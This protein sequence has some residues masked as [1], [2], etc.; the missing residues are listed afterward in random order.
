MSD[1]NTLKKTKEKISTIIKSLIEMIENP[2]LPVNNSAYFYR[3]LEKNNFVIYLYVFKLLINDNSYLEMK[4]RSYINRFEKE[5][6]CNL[7]LITNIEAKNELD[8]LYKIKK[9]L[10]SLE[11]FYDDKINRLYFK[12]DTY[13]DVKWLIT[14]I[15]LLLDNTKKN[16]NKEINICYTIPSKDITKVTSKE[17]KEEFLSQFTYYNI[18]VKKTDKTRQVRENNILIVKNAAINYLKHLK[19][20]KHGLEDEE[21]YLIFYNLLKNECRKEGFDLEETEKNL[22]EVD[23]KY[24]ERI[25]SIIDDDFY[26]N[27]L[28]KQIHIIENMVWQSSND[29]TLL[30]HTNTSIDSFIDL[31]TILKLESRHTYLEVKETH[32]INDIK[33][34]L[35]LITNQFLLTYLNDFD[36]I[37]YSLIDLNSIKPKYM[38]SICRYK[39]QDIK[40]KLRSS[41]IELT[42]AKKSL[43]ENKAERANLDKEAL[44]P[45][46]YQKELELCVSK[47]NRDSIVIARLNSTISSLTREYETLK[48]YQLEKYRNVDLYNYNHS[49]IRHICNSILGC[50]YYLKTNNNQSLF[51]NIIIFEDYEKTDNSFYLEVTFKELLKIS[52]QFLLNG[53]MDQSDLP[54]LA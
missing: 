4:Y 29:I 24:L 26:Q 45:D 35:L 44:G 12:D 33:I 7:K 23:P 14:I 6:H 9:K 21:S 52:S 53:I 42:S 38:N 47:I 25:S 22:L 27:Q 13:I 51:N 20:F 19:Q 1:F 43:E 8:L 32:H 46:K 37:D 39:E 40:N 49:I 34:L 54:K 16:D 48:K 15:S 50:N 18:K 30:E 11:Y 17:E 2:N 28:S 10:S 41:N 36:E 31:L 5:I 3:T